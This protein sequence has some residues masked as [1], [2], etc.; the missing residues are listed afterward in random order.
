MLFNGVCRFFIICAFGG[1]PFIAES[2][3]S[4]LSVHDFEWRFDVLMGWGQMRV[5]VGQAGLHAD[6]AF[7]LF[8]QFGHGSKQASI[9]EVA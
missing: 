9:L 4:I 8:L 1:K 2:E 7:G 6:E 3:Q 5:T